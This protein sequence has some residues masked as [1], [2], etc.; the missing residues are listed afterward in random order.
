MNLALPTGPLVQAIGWGLL[1][2]LWQ[3]TL[4]AAL[5]PVL[6]PIPP[7]PRAGARS[8]APRVAPPLI[9]VLGVASAARSYPVATAAAPAIQPASPAAPIAHPA[10]LSLVRLP[11]PDRLRAIAGSANR[12]LPAIVAV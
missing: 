7:R 3:G 11:A 1:H 2:L 12:A 9:V 8:V 6:L 10:K 4:V 5:L